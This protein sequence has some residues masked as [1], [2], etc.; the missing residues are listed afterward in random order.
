M[1]KSLQ[2]L[3]CEIDGIRYR[4][5][6]EHALALNLRGEV[7]EDGLSLSRVLNRLEIEWYARDIHPWDRDR[8]LPPED[9]AYLVVQQCLSDTEAAISRLFENLP[10]VDVIEARV[11]EPKSKI[12]II[13]GTVCRSGFERNDGLSV[14]MRLMLSGVTFRL[15]GWYFDALNLAD[16]QEDIPGHICDVHATVSV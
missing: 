5:G 15:S 3:L 4:R 1:R 14:G 10:Q 2:T 9:R 12:P 8:D 6:I 11:L 13:A 16:D 7:R